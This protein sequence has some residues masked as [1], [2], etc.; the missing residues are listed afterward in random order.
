MRRT[1][2]RRLKLGDLD[3]DT[4]A[5]FGPWECLRLY[6]IRSQPGVSA[7]E[8]AS[9]LEISERH[10]RRLVA[11][12]RDLFAAERVPRLE[13][14]TGR[15]PKQCGHDRPIAIGHAVLCLDCLVSG[16]DEV[17]LLTALPS[18]PLDVRLPEP[19]PEPETRKQK[20]AKLYG[21]KPE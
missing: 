3:R 15:Q 17:D 1:K 5:R 19:E 7:E 9:T 8:L 16:F 13:L 12:G 2:P 14:I 11:I 20:R 10:L 18:I 6:I 21:E 4:H